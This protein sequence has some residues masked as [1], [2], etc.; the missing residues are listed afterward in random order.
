MKKPLVRNAANEKQ[1]KRAREREELRRDTVIDDLKKV[2][3]TPY[4]RRF[5]RRLIVTEAGLLKSSYLNT[6][7]GKGSDP[8]FMEGRRSIGIDL[9]D[10]ISNHCY[11]HWLLAL[12]EEHETTRREL[13]LINDEENNDD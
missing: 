8:V 6:P 13:A 9:H 1:V 2:M 12:A 5:V 4:G 10:Q 3:A 11:D 7:T